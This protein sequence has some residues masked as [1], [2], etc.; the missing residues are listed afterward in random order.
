MAQ[1]H[2][3]RAPSGR[4]ITVTLPD[5]SVVESRTV[6]ARLVS[7]ALSAGFQ[8]GPTGFFE[9]LAN[10]EQP[11][12]VT[13]RFVLQNRELVVATSADGYLTT[14]AWRG[15]YHDVGAVF[16]GP[17]PQ[18]AQL[19][20]YFDAFTY[21][22]EPAG[23]AI[24]TPSPGNADLFSETLGAVI[25]D[26]GQIVVPSVKA[27]RGLMPD[28]RGTPS[29]HG[30]VWRTQKHPDAPGEGVRDYIYLLGTPRGFAEI[31]FFLNASVSDDE[32]LKWLDGI[33]LSWH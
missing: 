27:A 28:H 26:R 19:I 2:E 17:A 11:S 14:A 5:E 10:Y 30:E 3:W 16:T 21:N 9:G 12:T 20:Q 22:D 15:P 6:L 18:R 4:R 1:P 29:T 13:D 25:R 33:D 8:I 31:T 23:V 7:T 24:S 32:L